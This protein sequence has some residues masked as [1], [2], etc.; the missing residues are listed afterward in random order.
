MNSVM[1]FSH[2][3]V[4]FIDK[5][6]HLN[7]KGQP[8]RLSRHQRRVLKAAFRWDAQGR[9]R[10]RTLLWGEMKKSGKTF[11]AGCLVLWWSF[12]T[13]DTEVICCANDLE[14]S[15]GR[16]FKTIIKLLEY[17]PELGLSAKSRAADITLT[18]GT[19]ITAI[20]SDYKGAAGSRHSLVVFDELWGYTLEAAERLFE[21]LTTIP[22]EQS[23]WMLVV[24]TAGWV[25]ESIVLERL[26]KQGLAGTRIDKELEIYKADELFMFW[27]HTPRQPWQTPKYYAEQRRSLRRNTYDRL[28]GNKWVL[29][30]SDFLTPELWDPCVD[31]TH[32]PFLPS[33]GPSKDSGEFVGVDLG[34]K[35]DNAAVVRVRRREN[36]IV[37]AGYR[38]WKPSKQQPLDLESTVE[39]HLR[40][41]HGQ[42]DLRRIVVDP[43]QAARSIQTLMRAG[44]RIEEFPQTVANTTRM[45]QALYDLVKG[46]NLVLYEDAE[47]RQQAMNTV[48]VEGPRG[49]R[50]AKEKASR[51]IDLIIS[52][53]MACVAALDEPVQ[54]TGRMVRYTGF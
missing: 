41:L 20:A 35:S 26:Y 44:L 12:V 25:G 18:N 49:F 10:M 38:V 13:P 22:T 54:N 34:L 53:S 21:E 32:R 50:I 11:L 36:R 1:P 51:K 19:T 5:F 31:P 23:G 39:Q 46:R 30:E 15:V 47:L 33:W 40:T 37:L 24:T 7:E 9:L 17:N 3:P 4:A 2:D 28:H 29:G 52:L 45:G 42:Y 27:S 43:W 48:A 14:Q 6:V 8:W 16:V